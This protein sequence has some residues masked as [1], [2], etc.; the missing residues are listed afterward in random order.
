MAYSDQAPG[1][2]RIATIAGVAAIHGLLGFAFVTG[3][4]TNFV[5]EVSHTLTTTNVPLDVPPPPDTPPPPQQTATAPSSAT[6]ITTVVPRVPT[7]TDNPTVTV[8]LVPAPPL[9]FPPARIDVAPPPPAPP[10]I[11]KASG[12]RALGNRSSWITTEDYPAAALRAEDEGV[13]SLT[14]QVGSDGRVTGCSVT[15]SSG[16][17]TLDNA[18]CRLY[19]RR[20]RFEPARNDA[21]NAIATSY[22]DRVRWQ[23]PR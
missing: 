6:V 17:A 11:S 13:V 12:V 21:G 4:A 22:D 19:Q 9:S 16:S 1:S 5:R 3:M 18:T 7:L 14:V 10:V 20:A 2:R 23:L 15:A 8:D